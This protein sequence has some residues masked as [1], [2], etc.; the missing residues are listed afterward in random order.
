MS[1]DEIKLEI[2]R[3]VD[4]LEKNKLREIYG[5]M[6]NYLNSKRESDE[7]FSVSSYE[8]EGIK[9]AINE[10]NNGKS[11]PHEQVLNKLKTKYLNV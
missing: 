6:Q 11:I 9:A 5:L 1:I 2:F 3:Q 7:W 10:L 8:Q 4:A